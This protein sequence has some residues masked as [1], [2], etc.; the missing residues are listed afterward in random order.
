[1]RLT[2]DAMGLGLRVL[3][4]IA[5]LQSM[6]RLGLRKPA[7]SVIYGASRAGFATSGAASRVFRSTRALLQPARQ[8]PQRRGELFDLE[9]SPEQSMLREA[10]LDFA[11]EQLRP[12]ALQADTDLQIPAALR[13]ASGELGLHLLGV[14]EHLGGAG[15]ER[16]VIS[17]ALVAEALAQ[18]DLGLALA[19]L[20]PSAVCTALALWGDAGQ[21]STYL[22]A[23]I[24]PQGPAAALAVQEP[25]ALFDPFRLATGARRTPDGY[26]LDGIKSMVP[27]AAQA[28]LFIVAAH[29]EGRGPALFLVESS[30]PGLAVQAEPAMG[31]RAAATGRL[32]LDK[33]RLPL[34]ALVGQA[35]AQ[36]Y[37][38]CICLSR[39]G[40]CALAIG[41]AQAAL[42]YLVP[43]A[44]QR[45]A[46][47]EPISHRQSV[48]FALATMAID[49][50]SMRLLTWRAASCAEQALPFAEATALARRLCAEQ[51][52]R[53]GSDA[54]Q[55][56]GG[57]GFVKEHPVE[58]WYR[59]LRAVGFME[60]A[61]LL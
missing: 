26:V 52:M 61:V 37:A 23:L 25:A 9:P 31:L 46:F 14:P 1:M 30:N 28:E 18:G 34:T 58:R 41:T 60:G 49:I 32:L 29:L 27:L 7:E 5:G 6:D 45:I 24:G 48:A 3:N 59:D 57:H 2:R 16:S 15:P 43:Y 12:A 8:D 10:C 53:I 11:R 20:A 56:L 33:L 22:P 19:C 47:G 54:V 4:R 51:G 44:N 36:V 17:G 42:D 55:L 39:L 40:W 50:E 38:D 21:Q 13:D 35:Q